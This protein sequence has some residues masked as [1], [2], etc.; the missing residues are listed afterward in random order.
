MFETSVVD[1][2]A[3][4]E[5]AR[6]RE[7]VIVRVK[8]VERRQSAKLIPSCAAIALSVSPGWTTYDPEAEV[9]TGVAERSNS[10]ASPVA[11]AT[12]EVVP[13]E[14]PCGG[15]AS[16]E[17]EISCVSSARCRWPSP[18]ARPHPVGRSD[19]VERFTRGDY[20]E[21]VGRGGRGSASV[22]AAASGSKV[23]RCMCLS[24]PL[25]ASDT[26]PCNPLFRVQGCFQLIRTRQGRFQPLAAATSERPGSRKDPS[27]PVYGAASS[28]AF[29]FSRSRS[30]ASSRS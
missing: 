4:A 19:R 26:N 6:C 25:T 20:V 3:P 1:P 24:L 27:A 9:E 5:R 12:V 29:A 13:T 23:L 10:L 2:L 8:A 28:A 15:I 18:A 14:A 21:E 17:P 22:I 11:V 7:Q 30:P 16:V